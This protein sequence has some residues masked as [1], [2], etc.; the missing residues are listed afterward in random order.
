MALAMAAAIKGY[1][2]VLIMPETMSVE[3][4]K[5]LKH[6][7]AELVLTPGEKGMGGAIAALFLWFI[8][9]NIIYGEDKITAARRWVPVQ[10][11]LADGF[12]TITRRR[13][14]RRGTSPLLRDPGRLQEPIGELEETHAV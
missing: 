3:R 9:S 10:A 4:R 2:M 12:T 6:L 7:G 8:K 14:K 11:P 13:R 5:L 1:H